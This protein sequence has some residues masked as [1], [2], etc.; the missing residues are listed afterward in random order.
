MLL[1]DPAKG[2]TYAP[3]PHLDRELLLQLLKLHPAD[4]VLP[5]PLTAAGA[6]CCWADML[7]G[8]RSS[9]WPLC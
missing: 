5:E 8:W 9:S 6:R 1:S 3:E 4:V 2:L 7:L